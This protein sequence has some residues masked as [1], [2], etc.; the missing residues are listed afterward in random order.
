VVVAICLLAGGF[1]IGVASMLT[2]GALHAGGAVAYLA[3]IVSALIM[4]G[5]L[6]GV[7]YR[8]NWVRWITV[9]IMLVGAIQFFYGI[10]HM[11]RQPPDIL[12]WI[13][14]VSQAVAAVLLLLPGT[15]RWFRAGG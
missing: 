8:K 5:L 6:S 9:V 13:R 4:Y 12:K 2:K 3:I 1:V 15:G 14:V 7:F 11:P 10:S